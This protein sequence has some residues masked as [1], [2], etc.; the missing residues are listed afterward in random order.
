MKKNEFKKLSEAGPKK[1]EIGEK[2]L[3]GRAMVGQKDKKGPGDQI[4]YYEIIKVHSDT[5]Y[6][7]THRFEILEED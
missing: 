1:V 5:H 6:E 7:Y 4:T 2:F 3:E